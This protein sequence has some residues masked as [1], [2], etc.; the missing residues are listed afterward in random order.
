MTLV[1]HAP[2]VH[3]G[4]GKTLLLAVLRD[5]RA[6]QPCLLIGDARLDTGPVPPHIVVRTVLPTLAGRLRAERLLQSSAT[7][8]DVVLCM[9]NLPPLLTCAGRVVVF[10]QNRYLC[11][12]RASTRG[13]GALV[14]LRI[15][16]EREWLRRRL[17]RSTRVL[18]QTPSMQRSVKASL[19]VDAELA[20]FMGPVVGRE[21]T[22]GA[23]LRPRFLYPASDERH[24]NHMTLLAAWALLHS[25]GVDVEL[26]LTVQKDTP[27]GVRIAEARTTGLAI[28]N[29][30]PLG[31]P[32]LA[33]LYRSSSALIFPSG[34]ESFGLPLLEARAA[35]LP[36]VAA[37][38][39]YV[40]DVVEP[41]ETF[42]PDSPVSIARAVRR[43]LGREERPVTVLTPS[44]FIARAA[45]RA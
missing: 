27:L 41:E 42:E 31:A 25:A 33:E 13:L 29:H 12:V 10:L 15:A 43:M 21:A 17:T 35:G 2:N 19:N 5:V 40:R 20:P 22:R 37:E 36:I 28:V 14:R 18:V 3:V 7:A 45:Q 9:G 4:G 34:F 23:G 30:G 38:R 26:H 44:E 39:D 1:I 16:V 8:D 24:K 6:D 11:D 32:E